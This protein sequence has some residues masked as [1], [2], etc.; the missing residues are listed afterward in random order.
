M[1]IIIL[2]VSTATSLNQK[3]LEIAGFARLIHGTC[4]LL[5]PKNTQ[6]NSVKNFKPKK[7][8]QTSMKNKAK[9][10]NTWNKTLSIL[11]S[12]ISGESSS[13]SL[14][15]THISCNFWHL[16]NCSICPIGLPWNFGLRSQSTFIWLKVLGV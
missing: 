9:K 4:R 1:F 6:I 3:Q 8:N 12:E 13:S 15:L 5:R 16:T 10:R 7:N 11:H 2:R 14:Q